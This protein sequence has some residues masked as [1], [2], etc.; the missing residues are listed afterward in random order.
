[1]RG[2]E[3]KT[4]KKLTQCEEQMGKTSSRK[5]L[6]L[7]CIMVCKNKAPVCENVI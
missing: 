2:G 1:V 5:V 3:G 4:W 6:K 7:H